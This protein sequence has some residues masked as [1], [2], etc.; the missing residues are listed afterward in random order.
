MLRSAV[1]RKRI[2]VHIR[3]STKK[4]LGRVDVWPV[5]YILWGSALPFKPLIVDWQQGQSAAVLWK[6]TFG[7]KR[8]FDVAATRFTSGDYVW[9]PISVSYIP[10]RTPGADFDT[11][12]ECSLIKDLLRED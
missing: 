8:N 3:T 10:S 2:S 6:L 7:G 4:T 12:I 11:I 5:S 1:K 9:K